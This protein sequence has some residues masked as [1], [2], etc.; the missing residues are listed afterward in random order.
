MEES[1]TNRFGGDWTKKKLQVLDRY[2]ERY[3]TVLK[4]Q[5]FRRIYIDAFAGTGY[6]SIPTNTS[7]SVENRSQSSTNMLFDIEMQRENDDLLEGSTRIALQT[8]IPFDEYFFIE[9]DAKFAGKLHELKSEFPDTK[10]TILNGDANVKIV[11]ICNRINWK[12]TRAVVFLDPFGMHVNFNTLLRLAQTNAADVLNLFPLGVALNRMLARTGD[13]PH[14]W[15]TKL[16]EILGTEDW[17]SKIYTKQEQVDLFG[18]IHETV[19]KQSIY[20]IGQFYIVR[21]ESIFARVVEEPGILRNST[22]N[23][24]YLLCFAAAN[25]KGSLIATRIA[26]YL[27]RNLS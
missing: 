21:L 1:I 4:N 19:I 7:S 20:Q 26:R 12:R 17:Y 23:P 3:N 10:I 18:D 8:K 5:S 25:P 15:Q 24:M 9:K 16:N 11:E 14:G 2:L 13:I 27:L 6:T 22:N